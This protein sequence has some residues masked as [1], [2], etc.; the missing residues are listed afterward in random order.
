MLTSK[1]A[2]IESVQDV[3]DLWLASGEEDIFLRTLRPKNLIK[4]KRYFPVPLVTSLWILYRYLSIIFW[5]DDEEIGRLN[6]LI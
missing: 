5:I 4:L 6:T 2:A 3:V 1:T